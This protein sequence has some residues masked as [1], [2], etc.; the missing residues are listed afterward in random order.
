MIITCINRIHKES[1]VYVSRLPLATFSLA[2]SLLL[3][4]TPEQLEKENTDKKISTVTKRLNKHDTRLRGEISERKDIFA[5]LNDRLRLCE[6]ESS[7]LP[8]H[9][10]LAREEAAFPT[11]APVSISRR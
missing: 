10:R 5:R 11:N 6:H 8:K 3:Q 1:Y 9:R 4:R 7:V 2:I